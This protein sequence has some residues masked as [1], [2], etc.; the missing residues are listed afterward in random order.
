MALCLLTLG[1]FPNYTFTTSNFTILL[2]DN[3]LQVQPIKYN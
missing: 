1:A 2:Q 3:P